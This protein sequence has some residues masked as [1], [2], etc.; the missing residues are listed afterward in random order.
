MRERNLLFGVLAV[1]LKLVTSQQL[2]KA[3]AIWAADQS[4][5][6]GEI[7]VEQGVLA[8]P[9]RE[10]LGRLIDRQIDAQAGDATGPPPKLLRL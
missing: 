5:D 9:D 3:G 4:R 7:L 2:V 10:L 6:L 8:Q 1:Q